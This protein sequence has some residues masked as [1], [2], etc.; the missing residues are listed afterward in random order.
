VRKLP[1]PA[2]AGG[3]GT[4]PGR[5]DDTMAYQRS[6]SNHASLLELQ[7]GEKQIPYARRVFVNRNL[8]MASIRAIGFDMDHT[9]AVYRKLPTETLAFEAT[10]DKLIAEKGYP[11]SIASLQYDPHLIIRGLVVDK[12]L[13]NVLKTDQY[14]YV[15]RLY[16]G[17]RQVPK[18]ER[19]R[20]YRNRPIRLS[21][22]K[23]MSIDTLFGLP[24]ATL[25]ALLVDHLEAR[26]RR[27]LDFVQIYDDVRE[28]IDRAHAD[29]TIKRAI[30]AAP[31]HYIERH[32]E[33][34]PTLAAFRDQGKK[35][36]L[37]TNSEPHFTQ[38]VMSH[39]LDGALRTLPS[40]TD[41]FT[42]VVMSA[43]KPGF[44]RAVKQP[45]PLRRAELRAAGL[46]GGHLPPMLAGGGARGLEALIEHAGEEIL[47]VG[48]HTFGDILRAKAHSRWR[49]AM[50]VEELEPEIELERRLSQRYQRLD[51]LVQERHRLQGEIGRLRRRLQ[52]LRRGGKGPRRRGARGSG[53]V[54]DAAQRLEGKILELEAESGERAAVLRQ[55]REA[56]ERRFNRHWGKLFKCGE[57]NSR[58]GHQVKDFA[59]V[60]T[61]AVRN[62][63]AYP[64]SMYFRS[65]R[66]IM[67]HEAGLD[68]E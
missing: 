2:P 45:R 13:G 32:P 68:R 34:A 14:S 53:T 30:V 15:V 56:I 21:S 18:E 11:E 29:G 7:A 6:Q 33:L 63:L 44:F 49:T 12:L 17:T 50:V 58:F 16:H 20:L 19:R 36:F 37:L 67:P 25:F 3:V 66:E 51:A 40:W 31:G 23:Y 60:Y 4:D 41:Y 61:S 26:S 22:P 27:R 35:L 65:P 38:Q 46:P 42:A 62:F 64:E 55:L 1:G 10:R 52:N 9:L 24:E 28:C 8:K 57:I 39:L 47:Y 5:S 54:V 48:D 59:C 43:G